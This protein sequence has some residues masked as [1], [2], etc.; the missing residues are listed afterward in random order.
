MPELPEAESIGRALD[1]GLKDRTI[2]RVEVFTPAMRTPLTPLLSAGL[3]GRKFLGVRRRARYLLA[4]LDDG[5]ALLMHFGMSGV[6]RIEGPEVPKRKHEHV[7][8][9]LDNGKIFRF[10]CTRRFSLLEVCELPAGCRYPACLAQLGVEPLEKEF[11]AEYLYSA[12]RGKRLAVKSFIM[13]NA[14]VVGIGNIYANE[15]LFAA[16]ILPT[17]PAETLTEKECA[18]IVRHAVRILKAAIACGGTTFSDFLNVDGSEGKFVQHLEVYGK[19]GEKCPRCGGEIST[20]RIGG[21]NSF[22]C[23]NCQK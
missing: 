16:G 15:T 2:R 1:R 5:R 22:F 23:K 14:V 3:E 8:I 21:R 9:H 11:T 4:D 17:R 20:L 18:E 12:S 7:F 13:D 19:G 6:V 10:E